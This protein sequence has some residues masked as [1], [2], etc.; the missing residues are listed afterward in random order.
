MA[1]VIRRRYLG[2][3][4]AALGGLLAAACGEIEVRYV[5]GP[6]GPSG[7]AG[8]RGATGSAGSAGQTGAAGSAG[9]TQVVVQEKV[10]T[11]EKVVEK[12]V[13]TQKVPVKLTYLNKHFPGT[14]N[15]EW[16][17]L[18]YERMREE[19]PHIVFEHSPISTSRKEAFIVRASAGVP[20]HMVQNDW[21]VWLD[22]ARGGSILELTDHFK[23]EK[24]V[25]TETFLR[26]SVEQYSYAGRMFGFPL[27]QSSDSFPYNKGL[28][29]KAGLPHPPTDVTDQT[30]TM[31]TYLET[32]QKLK[33][34]LGE[35]AAAMGN[36]HGYH[37][38]RGTWYGHS[39][40]DD[41]AVKPT[42]DHEL[43]IK[44]NQFWQDLQ[45][46]HRLIM[47]SEFSKAIGGIGKGFP[48][49]KVAMYYTCCP[50]NVL[51]DAKAT[52]VEAGLATLPF[53]GWDTSGNTIFPGQNISGRVWP[54]NMHVAKEITTEEQEGAW[55]F[56]TWLLKDPKNGGLMPP[57][58]QHIVAPYLDETYSE[59]AQKDFESITGVDSVASS[60]P[61]QNALTEYPSFCGMLKYEEY[62]DAWNAIKDDWAK[63]EANEMSSGDFSRRAQEVFTNAGLGTNTL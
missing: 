50:H 63:H 27:S 62:S 31:E 55:T 16:D 24:V 26:W 30:W 49:G 39:S 3:A 47:D 36:G 12:V 2:G 58:N 14:V 44:G 34:A 38:N 13:E 37:W 25:P 45:H 53:S 20:A 56:F 11:V 18:M 29:D 46:K 42:M 28:F 8:A 60:A 5:Q 21:G 7:P 9:Q 23:R 59:A 33:Q 35:D 19:F 1:G 54:H 40:W 52:G 15:Y 61:L 57:S 48:A 6:A 41:V 51:R 17:N 43:F 32:L 4:A 22:L 10:I